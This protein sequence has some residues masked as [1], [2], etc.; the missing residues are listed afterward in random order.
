[1]ATDPQQPKS[2]ERTGGTAPNGSPNESSRAGTGL[3]TVLGKIVVERK[4]LSPEELEE[5][6]TVV[7]ERAK[8][9]PTSLADVLV[10][11]EFVTRKQLD[12]M[13]GDLDAAPG[14]VQVPGFE[15][16]R[17][18]GKGAMGKVYLGRQVSL[19]RAVAIKE[20]KKL[21]ASHSAVQRFLREAR[22]GAKLSHNNIVQFIEQ[23]QTGERYYLMMEY[24]DGDDIKKRIDERKVLPVDEALAVILQIAHA[25][26]HMHGR[27]IIHRDIK[28][29]NIMMTRGNVAK[30]AD[31][32]LARDLRDPEDMKLAK[33]EAGKAYGTPWYISP[34]QIRGR[35]DVGG[36]ADIYCLGATLYHMV[37][38]K[39]PFDGANQSEVFNA[40]LS[41]KLVPPDQRNPQIDE[42]TAL[43]IETMLQRDLLKRYRTARELI[44]DLE[45]CL[46]NR[47][48]P[49]GA[50]RA[51]LP[52]AKPD[53]DL[54]TIST[55]TY[56]GGRGS[57]GGDA[58][59]PVRKDPQGLF[60]NP[61]V[62]TLIVA[63]ALSIVLN[64]V[65]GVKA[66]L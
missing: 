45:T 37:T 30:L 48:L 20:M 9:T 46:A 26:D 42:D 5:L 25:L 35:E 41:G 21:D 49:A 50:D 57:G 16:T 58:V 53:V 55:S 23:A 1:V 64:V 7:S 8:S 29:A 33:A 63:L 17:Q 18:I 14:R 61:I 34:E 62:V 2:T 47:K 31:L 12:R 4:L 51:P 19:N 6:N 10:E 15:F 40:H 36:P 38:G 59:Q 54:T 28:P 11:R 32:G 13:R 65:L 27:G 3:D 43:I 44:E 52:H 39:V 22:I 24:I 66:V 56:S 60:S